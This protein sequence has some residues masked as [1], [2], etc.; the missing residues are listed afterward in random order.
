MREVRPLGVYLLPLLAELYTTSCTCVNVNN[1][2]TNWVSLI[3]FVLVFEEDEFKPLLWIAMHWVNW[4]SAKCLLIAKPEPAIL[5][6]ALCMDCM[7]LAE[8]SHCAQ[9]PFCSVPLSFISAV[10]IEKSLLFHELVCSSHWSE[11]PLKRICHTLGFLQSQT[12]DGL[13]VECR[14]GREKVTQS[15]NHTCWQKLW[16][17]I[18]HT[19]EFLIVLKVFKRM[20]FF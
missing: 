17:L 16:N 1:S 8:G 15:D 18:L 7:G 19:G 12:F 20:Q 13:K 3:S 14:N 11:K 6:Y 5:S 4:A 9:G 10:S 2:K